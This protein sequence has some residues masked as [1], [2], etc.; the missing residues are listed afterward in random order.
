MFSRPYVEKRTKT[1]KSG[2]TLVA[3]HRKGVIIMENPE[4]PWYRAALIAQVST[5]TDSTG[6]VIVEVALYET[7]DAEGDLIWSIFWNPAGSAGTYMFIARTGKW[8]GIE[9]V[10]VTSGMLKERSDD[11]NLLKSEIPWN[12]KKQEKSD[13]STLR[14]LSVYCV[15]GPVLF[16]LF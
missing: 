11:F 14:N 1:F 5:V 12:I 7:T 4:S 9:G 6:K 15:S 13:F 16:C 8:K 3:Y 10:G 2:N